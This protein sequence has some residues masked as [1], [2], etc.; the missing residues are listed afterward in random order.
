MGKRNEQGQ[1]TGHFEGGVYSGTS[2][3]KFKHMEGIQMESDCQIFSN[4]TDNGKD[5][6]QQ[7][8]SDKLWSTNRQS[9]SGHA[10]Q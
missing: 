5:G 10:P 1:I 4:T 6:A 8:M 9:K 3:Y 7:Q 2:S